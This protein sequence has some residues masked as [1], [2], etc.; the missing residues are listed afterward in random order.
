MC[1]FIFKWRF[2]FHNSG[3]LRKFSEIKS[4]VKNARIKVF[5]LSL[6]STCTFAICQQFAILFHTVF[7]SH[8]YGSCI[9]FAIFMTLKY[10]YPMSK[11][12]KAKNLK[13]QWEELNRCKLNYQIHLPSLSL[14][15]KANISLTINPSY[16]QT[17]PI[18]GM[19]QGNLPIN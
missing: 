18:E 16:L 9:W 12:N 10:I 17:Y 11:V 1:L 14:C 13:N 3:V 15:I 5:D 7:E 8:E 6:T 4:N 19:W 2:F